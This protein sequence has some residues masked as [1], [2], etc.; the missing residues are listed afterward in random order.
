VNLS[1]KDP[2]RVLSITTVKPFKRS[3]KPFKRSRGRRLVTYMTEP[4][5]IIIGFA[6][7]VALDY[8]SNS[9]HRLTFGEWWLAWAAWLIGQVIVFFLYE[10]RD[11]A[12]G[13]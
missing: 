7:A 2:I 11:W 9:P 8:A 1:N 5:R 12:R 6:A 13:R 4:A 10:A 3:R